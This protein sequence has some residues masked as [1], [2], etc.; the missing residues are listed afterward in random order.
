MQMM[1]ISKSWWIFILLSLGVILP[2]MAHYVLNGFSLPH[3]REVMVEEVLNVNIWVALVL[4]VAIIEWGILNSGK[5]K[6]ARITD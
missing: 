1:I 4:N 6:S 3:G 5:R 2:F